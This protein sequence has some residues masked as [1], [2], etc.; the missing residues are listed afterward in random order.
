MKVIHKLFTSI[1]INIFICICSCIFFPSC[2]PIKQ[3]PVE[4]V[5]NVKDTTIVHI[6]DSTVYIP[7]EVVKEIVNQYDTL[8][9]E[10]SKAWS[11]AYIDTNF[12]ILRGEINN[13]TGTEYKYIYKDKVQYKDSIVYQDVI[14]EVPVDKIVRKNPWYF[15]VL[16]PFTI[17]G[18]IIAIYWII[19]LCM[20]YFLHV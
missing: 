17:I 15:Y 8:Y 13:K 12:N 3:I 18:L 6:V 4:T 11:K 19:K 5:I 10:T 7:V 14:K 20:K 16:L 9:M 2:A 1:F